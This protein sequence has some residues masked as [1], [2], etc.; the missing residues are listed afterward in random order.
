MGLRPGLLLQSESFPKN[1]FQT[2]LKHFR[3]SYL[4]IRY[5]EANR[6]STRVSHRIEPNHASMVVNPGQKRAWD[7]THVSYTES[8]EAQEKST[9]YVSMV[10]DLVSQLQEYIVLQEDDDCEFV[11]DGGN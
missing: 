7:Q 6:P 3:R 9:K 1:S 5:F 8:M 2:E 10:K 4:Q 11:A